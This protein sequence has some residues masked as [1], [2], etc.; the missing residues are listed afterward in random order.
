MS[1]TV[2]VSDLHAPYQDLKAWAVCLA[3]IKALKPETIVVIGDFADCYSV[4]SFDRNPTR[5][6]DLKWEID[7]VRAELKKLCRLADG[8][9]AYCEGN[10]ERRLE[11]YLCSKAPELYGLISIRDLLL[12]GIRG[13]E[14]VPYREHVKIGKVLYT[15]DV[16]HA[17]VYAGR[18]T[19]SACG[20]NVVFG[21]T[22]RGGVVIDG[23]HTGDRRFSLNV[24]WLGDVEQVDYMHR[25]KT[26]DWTLG[27]GHIYTDSRTGLVWPSFVP[28]MGGG[29]Y[30]AG[31]WVKI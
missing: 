9:V 7:Q 13:V 21:H 17:G 16:G 20:H 15:H 19:L 30:V 26:K 6:Q 12:Q 10:H 24:G 22:H 18:H 29:C 8:R 11:R 23:D 5:R 31:K 1:H 4:S 2:I 3:A 14:W 25:I 28:V 27:F